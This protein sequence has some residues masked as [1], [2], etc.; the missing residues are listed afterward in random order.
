MIS[1]IF[2]LAISVLAPGYQSFNYSNGYTVQQYRWVHFGYPV[3][4]T[5]PMSQMGDI[6]ALAGD[7]NGKAWVV[8]C[9]NIFLNIAWVGAI[10]S[11]IAW[12]AMRQAMRVKV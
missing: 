4:I 10:S 8:Y 6:S 11:G 1:F 7:P 5:K 12:L 9:F 2:L 3:G